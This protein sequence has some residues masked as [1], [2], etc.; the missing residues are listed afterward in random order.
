MELTSV[1]DSFFFSVPKMSSSSRK[2]IVLAFFTGFGLTVAK[3][4][5]LWSF[6]I[7][8][9]GSFFLEA[10]WTAVSGAFVLV[11]SGEVC[12]GT[13]AEAKRSSEEN[14]SSSAE[15]RIFGQT[16][17]SESVCVGSVVVLVVIGSVRAEGLAEI[18]LKADGDEVI[19]AAEPAWRAE[20][21]FGL[22]SWASSEFRAAKCLAARVWGR[23]CI[24][25]LTRSCTDRFRDKLF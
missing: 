6:K 18:G 23:R 13:E 17:P 20:F 10:P 15:G 5:S 21:S 2:G 9:A 19:L 14:K 4:S 16:A 11:C 7:G 8:R 1:L 24:A 25:P 22:S 12:L 3:R